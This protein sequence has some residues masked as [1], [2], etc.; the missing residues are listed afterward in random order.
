MATIKRFEDL[1]VWQLD[2][3]LAKSVHHIIYN[4]EIKNDYELRNQLSR[5]IGSVMD[6]IAE[7]FE[8]GGRKEF[9]QFLVIAK[10]SCGEAKSQLY[11]ALDKRHITTETFEKLISE[12]DKTAFKLGAFLQYLK[13]SDIEGQR[14]K[15]S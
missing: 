13:K 6:N 12:L 14:Y 10:G 5:S 3:E 1:E 4:T 7:G 8:R 9:I 2:R 15:T 11:R